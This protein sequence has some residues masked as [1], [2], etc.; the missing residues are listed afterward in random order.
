MLLHVIQLR[1]GT[2]G[3]TLHRLLLNIEMDFFNANSLMEMNEN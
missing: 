3:P 1:N 2:S